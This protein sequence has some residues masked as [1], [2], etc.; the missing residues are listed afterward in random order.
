MLS[1]YL[2]ARLSAPDISTVLILHYRSNAETASAATHPYQ[3]SASLKF[4]GNTRISKFGNK[5]MPPYQGFIP[6]LYQP[7]MTRRCQYVKWLRVARSRDTCPLLRHRVDAGNVAFDGLMATRETHAV[8]PGSLV[9]MVSMEGIV[10]LDYTQASV[11][12]NELREI[13][14]TT[15]IQV[16]PDEAFEIC[17][18]A[19]VG[20]FAETLF[21]PNSTKR[22]FT[23]SVKLLQPQLRTRTYTQTG[24]STLRATQV[25]AALSHAYAVTYQNRITDKP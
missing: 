13:C 15:V 23:D 11:V 9:V 3:P 22:A 5:K 17:M 25:R 1:S 24:Q 12:L 8:P 16:H 20:D 18:R 4:V 10:M 6:V 7:L 14:D 2:V 21:L 19:L